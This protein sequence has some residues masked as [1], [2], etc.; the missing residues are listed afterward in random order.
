MPA[1]REWY[2][3]K[4]FRQGLLLLLL[5]IAVNT[6]LSLNSLR[7]MQ[8]DESLVGRAHAVLTQ[9]ETTL[10]TLQA[11]ETGQRG[12][13]YT[14]RSDYLRPYLFAAEKIDEQ[15]NKLGQMTSDNAHQQARVATLR[16]IVRDKMDEIART[17]ALHDA[18]QEDAARRLVLT[19]VGQEKMNEI[20]RLL[21]EMREE[22]ENMVLQRTRQSQQT[23]RSGAY[24]LA[25]STGLA[26]ALTFLLVY[27]TMRDVR[28]GEAAQS[29]IRE[30]QAWL[31]TTLRSIGDGVIATDIEG[32][33]KFLNGVAEQLTGWRSEEAAGRP[34]TEVFAIFDEQTGQPAEQ[35]VRYVLDTRSVCDIGNHTVLRNRNGDEFPIYDSAA[36][37]IDECG[38]ISGVVLVFRDD[39][40]RRRSEATLV[41][42]EKLAATG[43]MAATLAHEI[44]NP[45]EAA[46]NLLYLAQ[47]APGLPTEAESQIKAAHAQ[48]EFA[49]H[50]SRRTLTMY[51]ADLTPTAAQLEE[52]LNEVVS[53]YEGRLRSRGINLVREYELNHSVI[54]NAADMRQVFTNII[55][56]AFDA[57]GTGD[58][59]TLRTARLLDR[60]GDRAIVTVEDTGPGISEENRRRLFEPFFTTKPAVGTGLG[61]WVSKQI[62]EKNGGRLE[63]STETAPTHHGTRVSMLLPM[64]KAA[65]DSASAAD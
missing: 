49:A 61:L 35:P 56:N 22:E 36:P 60:Y 17:I 58:T 34:I 31:Q 53:F 25:I 24:S 47:R 12:Y 28:K 38:E 51:R 59:I 15:L 13:L 64:R 32:S 1:S 42:A 9:I 23:A 3:E 44:N 63:L 37:I 62:V 4:R 7:R 8:Q 30:R 6:A 26:V 46:M 2:L 18:G 19:D 65:S 16:P 57:C 52:V 14:N 39:T 55:S 43:R 20:R 48:L 33:V 5:A 41:R 40:Q 50:A 27:V 11:A 21:E 29:Q 45:L 10:S 54:T